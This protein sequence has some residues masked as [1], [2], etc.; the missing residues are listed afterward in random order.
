MTSR[1]CAPCPASTRQSLSPQH[2]ISTL[3][4]RSSFAFRYF[5]LRALASAGEL[6]RGIAVIHACWDI[7]IDLGATTSWETS[8]PLW[9]QFLKENDGVPAFQVRHF[10]PPFMFSVPSF[11]SRTALLLLH[12]HGPAALRIGFHNTCW[13]LRWT[14]NACRNREEC[15][16]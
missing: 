1:K 7:M 6:D 15:G 16:V 13:G 11:V 14:W 10:A 4:H 2:P 5:I 8:K 3:Q 9:A 12:I